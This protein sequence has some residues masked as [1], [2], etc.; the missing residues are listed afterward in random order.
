MWIRF[1]ILC[2]LFNVYKL[3][4]A[5]AV[6]DSLRLATAPADTNRVLLLNKLSWQVA[7]TDSRQAL[8]YGQQSLKLA[9]QLNFRLGEIYSLSS[10]GRAAYLHQDNLAALRYYQASLRLAEQEPRGARQYTLALLGLGRV[11]IAQKDFA[12]GEMYFRQ[13]LNRFQSGIHLVTPIDIGMGQNHLA[14]LYQTWLRSGKPAP[15]S[16]KRLHERYA[17]LALASFRR[18]P[19]S[20]LNV[21]ECLNGMGVAHRLAGRLDSAAYCQL[22][23]IGMLRRLRNVYGLAVAQ[24]DLAEVRLLQGQEP[25][26]A[27]LIQP[28]IAWARQLHATGVEARSHQLLAEALAAQGQGMAAYRE[29]RLSQVLFDSLQS[30]ER[31]EAFTRLQVQFN[32]ER[33]SSRILALTQRNQLQQAETHKERQRLLLVLAL[34]AAVLVGLAATGVL[35]RRLRRNQAQLG[36]QN[37]ELTATRAEQD[38]LYALIAHDIRG[39][40]LAFGGLADLLTRYVEAQ[41]TTRLVRLSGRVREAAHNLRSLLENLLSWARTQRGEL[42]AIPEPLDIA[43]LLQEAATL[44]QPSADAAGITLQV[45][46]ATGSVLADSHMTRTVLRNLLGNALRAT[47]TGGSITLSATP[48]PNEVEVELR[49]SDTGSGLTAAD[50]A[51]LLGPPT[52]NLEARAGLGLRL[53]QAFASAQGGW[54]DLRSTPGEGTS[55]VLTLPL[56]LGPPQVAGAGISEKQNLA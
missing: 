51:R 39:P 54:L 52:I 55:A 27:V 41:D 37:A 40:V 12:E 28:T 15:D 29:N 33:Q 38:R 44:Y 17:R 7:T 35:A 16:V 22:E 11:A 56:A 25:A 4:L 21:A 48:A 19:D 18:L 3:A 10:L 13:A 23:A 2:F 31:R 5:Q 20:D 42:V 46:P 24:Q 47:P 8:A 30:T 45:Q 9:R 36:K 14:S 43:A 34:L 53:S 1:I 49:V 50:I 32:T 26:A 6:P